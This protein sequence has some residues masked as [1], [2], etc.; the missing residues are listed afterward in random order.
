METFAITM[1]VLAGITTASHTLL[2]LLADSWRQ[3]RGLV[4]SVLV[5]GAFTAWGLW[6]I[7]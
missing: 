1:T 3:A 2:A 6:V 5:H 7:L 4:L